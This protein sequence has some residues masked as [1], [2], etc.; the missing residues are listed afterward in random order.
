MTERREWPRMLVAP[1][2][3]GG[4]YVVLAQYPGFCRTVAQVDRDDAALAPLFAVSPKLLQAIERST[5]LLNESLVEDWNEGSAKV[6]DLLIA[7]LVDA[8]DAA[9]ILEPPPTPRCETENCTDDAMRGAQRC[10]GHRA[11][12]NRCFVAGCTYN[13]LSGSILC[14]GHRDDWV[15]H[16]PGPDEAALVAWLLACPGP[17]APPALPRQPAPLPIPT[18]ITTHGLPANLPPAAPPRP[19][20]VAG[21][22]TKPRRARG[23]LC[24]D[25]AREAN[26]VQPMGERPPLSVRPTYCEGCARRWDGCEA[27]G[28]CPVCREILCPDHARVGEE[29]EHEHGDDARFL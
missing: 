4:G 9:R 11:F 12:S 15:R 3:A 14:P 18:A 20:C 25:H 8:S 5:E 21:D 10:W 26:A 16:R 19:R 28:W 6:Y 2:Q 1:A 17:V 7:A 29:H 27:W 13:K 22:C 23:A 24:A